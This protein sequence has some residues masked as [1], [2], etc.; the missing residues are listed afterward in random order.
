VGGGGAIARALAAE[1]ACV[2]VADL[3]GDA[4]GEVAAAI[5]ADGGESLPLALDLSELDSFSGHLDLVRE[6]F[7][8]VDILVNLTGGPPPTPAVG[9]EP[10]LWS[11][12]F[13]SMVLGV[14][15]LTDLVLPEMRERGFGRVVT[16]TSSGVVAP[17]PNLG[18]S[19]SLR[20][21]LVGW[22]KTLSREV[23]ADGVTVNLIVPGRIAT[24]RI[25]QLDEA[26]AERE[27]TDVASVAAASAASIPVGR[28]GEPAEYGAA[29]AFLASAQASY[30][31]GATLRVDG[32]L[33]PSIS[34]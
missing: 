8:S 7:G 29:V 32:G 4:A 14:I 34:I 1:K 2:A 6:R 31:T 10:E 11:K 33:I 3:S 25:K 23:A 20:S 24:K 13:R 27:G 26:R 12:H 21:A 28:Y 15:H 16:S 5:E 30:I 17:I 18:V 19:N 22:A 9:V